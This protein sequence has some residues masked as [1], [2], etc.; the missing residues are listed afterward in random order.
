M[1]SS[2]YAQEASSSSAG[3]AR[4]LWP[5][6]CRTRG[7]FA[8]DGAHVGTFLAGLAEAALI[9]LDTALIQCANGRESGSQMA[10]VSWA[11]HCTRPNFIERVQDHDLACT[12][13]GLF[14]AGLS[15]MEQGWDM[16]QRIAQMK[17][18][19]EDIGTLRAMLSLQAP[20]SEN[21]VRSGRLEDERSKVV[22][23]AEHTQPTRVIAPP[24]PAGSSLFETEHPTQVQTGAGDS[25]RAEEMVDDAAGRHGADEH[26]PA[27]APIIANTQKSTGRLQVRLY[28]KKAAHTLEMGPHR[29]GGDFLGVHV[30]SL[31][32]ARALTGGGFDWGRKLVFQFTPEEMPAAIAV[33]MNLRESAIFG[34][35]GADRN[36][37][38]ELRWQDSGLYVVTSQ[39]GENFGVPVQPETVFYLLSLFCQAMAQG[40]QGGTITETMALVRAIHAR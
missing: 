22:V 23:Q 31:E 20:A 34:Q 38:C 40:H 17:A 6:V 19:P 9:Q 2:T 12:G 28:G 35:H 29:R 32:S 18:A 24:D 10:V 25:V 15:L 16:T 5:V 21:T 27:N 1:D 30:V 39:P 11:A 8:P 14:C 13:S 36:K 26:S 37:S 4:K 33:L 3:N 7:T